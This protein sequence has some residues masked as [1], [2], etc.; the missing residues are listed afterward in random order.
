MN[1]VVI[2]TVIRKKQTAEDVL[3]IRSDRTR[4]VHKIADR[5]TIEDELFLAEHL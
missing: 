3:F 4:L 5:R 2:R 1:H